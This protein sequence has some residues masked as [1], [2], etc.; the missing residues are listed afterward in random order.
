MPQKRSMFSVVET[1]IILPAAVTILTLNK[2]SRSMP[3]K[4]LYLPT[5]PP[6]VAPIIP[7]QDSEPIA[8]SIL[9]NHDLCRR[10]REPT[11]FFIGLAKWANDISK[12][13]CTANG[14]S[15]G[16]GI[17]TDIF[18][19]REIKFDAML[20]SSKGN[21]K[22]MSSPCRQERSSRVCGISDLYEA[23]KDQFYARGRA[24]KRAVQS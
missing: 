3:C 2:E 19:V 13:N 17:D 14:Q 4:P 20:K 7:T 24:R 22:A 8:F 6:S 11:E 5:P 18:E 12:A 15:V 10:I 1:V 9:A 21:C 23:S 16:L